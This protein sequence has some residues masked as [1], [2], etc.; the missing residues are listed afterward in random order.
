MKVSDL[1]FRPRPLHGPDDLTE[2]ATHKFPNGYGVSVLR[3]GESAYTDG[4]TYE[5]AVTRDGILDYSTPI[6]DDVLAYQTEEEAN[7]ALAAIAALPPAPTPKA[8]N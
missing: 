6:T 4:G 3:G 8:D 2:K 1:T 7:A 5:I